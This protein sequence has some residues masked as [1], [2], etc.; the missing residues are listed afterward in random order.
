[1]IQKRRAT[2]TE[3]AAEPRTQLTTALSRLEKLV[4]AVNRP[5]EENSAVDRA[6][7]ELQTLS[8]KEGIPACG[9]IR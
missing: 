9:T 7:A 6:L 1:M 5:G 4:A 3:P 8:Q 2:L